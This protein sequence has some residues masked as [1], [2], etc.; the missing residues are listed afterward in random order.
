[1]SEFHR[2]LS[3]LSEITSKHA[4]SSSGS[5]ESDLESPR[6]MKKVSKKSDKKQRKKEEKKRKKKK[7]EK[8]SSNEKKRKNSPANEEPSSERKRTSHIGRFK[9]RESSKMVKGY[10]S[11]DLA[12]I[13]GEDPFAKQQALVAVENEQIQNDRQNPGVARESSESLENDQSDDDKEVE[14]N[15]LF[16]DQ[17]PSWWSDYFIKGS[18]SGSAKQK[19]SLR[20]LQKGFSEQDQENLYTSAHD[21]ATQGRVGL[22]RSSMPKKV[23]GVRWAGTKKKLDSD[24]DD[25]CN[26]DEDTNEII[27]D[28]NGAIEDCKIRVIL[29]KNKKPAPL[30]WEGILLNILKENQSIKLKA[31]VKMTLKEFKKTSQGEDAKMELK[32]SITEYIKNGSTLFSVKGKTV[33]LHR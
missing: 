9:K 2:V 1:M 29:P 21:G 8:T 20:S 17:E 12:A 23:G 5:E 28:D 16:Q 10:S 32:S 33:T 25:E 6:P 14:E 11:S 13:L 31:L 7:E 18:K 26:V 30:S 15:V 22:G 27:E 4:C 19:A 24:S 3:T